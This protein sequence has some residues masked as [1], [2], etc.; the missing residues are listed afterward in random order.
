MGA[1]VRLK[2]RRE[3]VKIAEQGQKYVTS[4]LILQA[5]F[6]SEDTRFQDAIRVGFTTSRKVGNAVKRNRVRRRLREV[7]RF[8]LPQ[9][10][11]P[12]TDYVIIGRTKTA[13]RPFTCLIEDLKDALKNTK[14]TD[15]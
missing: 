14:G 6:R 3:F 2:K 13:D 4:G 7:A 10:G 5:L 8:V 12:G 11:Q 1:L 9:M 15:S